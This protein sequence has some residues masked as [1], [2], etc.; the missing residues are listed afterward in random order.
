M[1]TLVRRIERLEQVPGAD[2]RPRVRLLIIPAVLDTLALGPDKDRIWRALNKCSFA[3]GR[4]VFYVGTGP[5]G[6]SESEWEEF[7]QAHKRE[8]PTVKAD[9]R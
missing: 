7:Q 5:G 6:L 3:P 1:R 4:A 2:G 8:P 9:S